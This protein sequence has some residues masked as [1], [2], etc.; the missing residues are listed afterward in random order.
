MPAADAAGKPFLS[1]QDRTPTPTSA[2][3]LADLCAVSATL[4]L[5][6]PS[7]D[8]EKDPAP[9][10]TRI[11]LLMTSMVKKARPGTVT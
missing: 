6:A 4:A 9:R 11:Q 1:S 3:V 8:S 10:S 5:A 7:V 2:A